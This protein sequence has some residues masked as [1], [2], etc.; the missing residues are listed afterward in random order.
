MVFKNFEMGS[1]W[2]FQI[3]VGLSDFSSEGSKIHKNSENTGR[4]I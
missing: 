1:G 4:S 3:E 2:A